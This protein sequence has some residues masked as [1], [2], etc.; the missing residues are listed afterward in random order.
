MRLIESR[1]KV[2]STI[3]YFLNFLSNNLILFYLKAISLSLITLNTTSFLI[4]AFINFYIK[5]SLKDSKYE[6]NTGESSS[7]NPPSKES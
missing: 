2:K 5:I 4:L 7:N 1:S 6:K 3:F